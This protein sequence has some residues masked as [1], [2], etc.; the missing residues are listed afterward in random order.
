MADTTDFYL[1]EDDNEALLEGN[2]NKTDWIVY[3]RLR[4]FENS[5]E[6]P[7]A[8]EMIQICGYT[9]K[10]FYKSLKKLKGLHLSPVWA[11]VLLPTAQEKN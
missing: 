3:I 4:L 9:A 1:T 2:L 7:D 11:D 8:Q 6:K 10:T 5:E